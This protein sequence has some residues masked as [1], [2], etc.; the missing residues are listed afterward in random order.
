MNML[1]KYILTEKAFK[2]SEKLNQYIFLVSLRST[3]QSIRKTITDIYNVS[4]KRVNIIKYKGKL[5]SKN[6]KNGIVKG[7]KSSFKKAIV[8]LQEGEKI[9]FY[10][11]S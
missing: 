6:T 3:K 7:K 1:K 2:L 5:K 10:E 4:V 11:N 9:N 8:S